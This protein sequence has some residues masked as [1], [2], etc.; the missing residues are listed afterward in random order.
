MDTY[1]TTEAIHT[2][3]QFVLDDYDFN[4]PAITK[5][6]GTLINRN[7]A[8]VYDGNGKFCSLSMMATR[9][10]AI[11]DEPKLD[12][13]RCH[14]AYSVFSDY[15]A[16]MRIAATSIATKYENDAVRVRQKKDE[17]LGRAVVLSLQKKRR[18][19]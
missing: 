15:N 11:F 13:L 6:Y 16:C 7:P 14:E 4:I 2:A 18:A 3:E 5:K 10:A 9:L 12:I 19:K 8:T 17:M 1:F